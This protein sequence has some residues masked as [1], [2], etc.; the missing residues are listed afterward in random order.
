MTQSM[1][2]IVRRE[3]NRKPVRGKSADLAQD[4]ALVAEVE[5]CGRFVEEDGARL[6]R[7]R[8]GDEREL[9]LA[10]GNARI[11]PSSEMGD[12][13]PCEGVRVTSR[14]RREGGVKTEPQALRPMRTTSSTEKAK[15]PTWICGTKVEALGAGAHRHSGKIGAVEDD[16]AFER[17]QKSEKGLEQ[18]RLAAAV[19]TK[20]GQHL[21]ALERQREAA[22]DD[23]VA[24]ADG[25]RLRFE[26]HDQ[27]R[28]AERRSAMKT[29]VPMTAVRMPRGIST[30]AV[31]RA[32]V[33]MR[34][35]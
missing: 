9:P 12:A 25:K 22:S 24:I 28:W 34:R 15:V 5:A 11:G 6:L 18:G 16:R 29:G 33:S 4:L 27:L 21:A 30:V 1:V 23:A 32:R 31:A 2:R 10:A 8:P 3:R 14:S 7:Q 17:R 26:I 35:R 13:E 20:Q 19:R